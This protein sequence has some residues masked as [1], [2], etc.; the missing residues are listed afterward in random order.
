MWHF[1]KLVNGTVALAAD[2]NN[3]ALARRL[4]CCHQPVGTPGSIAV[5]SVDTDGDFWNLK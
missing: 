2:T 1:R 3:D 4:P 5:A